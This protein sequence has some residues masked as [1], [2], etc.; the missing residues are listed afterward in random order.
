MRNQSG[1]LGIE[2]YHHPIWLVVLTPRA[3]GAGYSLSL[4]PSPHFICETSDLVRRSASEDDRVPH[5]GA[6]V[7]KVAEVRWV[8]RDVGVD[9]TLLRVS[10]RQLLNFVPRMS[11]RYW[12]KICLLVKFDCRFTTVSKLQKFVACGTVLRSGRKPNFFS[13]PAIAH[14]QSRDRLV[15]LGTHR[16]RNGMS[17]RHNPGAALATRPDRVRILLASIL[18]IQNSVNLTVFDGRSV[19]LIGGDDKTRI[20]SLGRLTHQWAALTKSWPITSER[21]GAQRAL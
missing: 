18:K 3:T 20:A 12:S 19:V 13:P 9:S 2:K 16:A 5:L 7:T 6:I 15:H 10:Q 17:A 1:C 21:P 4:P 8:F 11:A 14:R